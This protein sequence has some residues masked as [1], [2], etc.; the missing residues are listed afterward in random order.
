MVIMDSPESSEDIYLR[1]TPTVSEVSN[2][3][4]DAGNRE[5][6]G[7]PVRLPVL[8]KGGRERS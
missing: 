6:T 7:G 1:W 8:P 2:I 5:P 3:Y 4:P